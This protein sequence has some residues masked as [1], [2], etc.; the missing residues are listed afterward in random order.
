M[1]TQSSFASSLLFD[2]FDLQ[3][4]INKTIKEI[5]Y[6]YDDDLMY[7]ASIFESEKIKSSKFSILN[8][9]INYFIF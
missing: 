4:F 3:L 9:V 2:L 7:L 8:G 1:E 5:I 6:G